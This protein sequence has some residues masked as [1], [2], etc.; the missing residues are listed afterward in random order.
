M[1]RYKQFETWYPFNGTEGTACNDSLEDFEWFV[2]NNPDA[3]PY[4]IKKYFGNIVDNHFDYL[5]YEKAVALEFIEISQQILKEDFGLKIAVKFQSIGKRSCVN[6]KLAVNLPKLVEVFLLNENSKKFIESR[7]TSCSGF[8]SYYE[9]NITDWLKT[10]DRDHQH[11]IGAMLECLLQPYF[12]DIFEDIVDRV[13][14]WNFL[15]NDA[16]LNEF[17][18]N[19]GLNF[20]SLSECEN[21]ENK[22]SP[23]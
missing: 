7:Y 13:D 18:E 20:K 23:L 2:W 1:K 14:F 4:A 8:M 12:D 16:L 9:S 10:V 17:N 11:K 5:G 6:V 3:V 19:F 22:N 15:D 21:L